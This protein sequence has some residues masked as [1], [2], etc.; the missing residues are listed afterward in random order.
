MRAPFV[1]VDHKWLTGMA[2]ALLLLGICG[3]AWARCDKH[4][5]STSTV[6]A[7]TLTVNGVSNGR[8]VS[9]WQP[10]YTDDRHFVGCTNGGTAY[11][12]ATPS[13]VGTYMDGGSTYSVYPTGVE[14][15]GMIIGVRSRDDGGNFQ[16]I[17]TGRTAQIPFR[18][19]W[20]FPQVRVRFI[21][22]GEI[23]AG[24]H[25]TVPFE[26]AS[27]LYSDST[28]VKATVK[29]SLAG[30]TIT[31]EHRPLCRPAPVPV[32]MGSVPA[33]DFKGQYSGGRERPF[34]I[35]VDCEAGVGDVNFYL[36]P[37][38]TSPAVDVARGIVAVSGGAVG[39]G[40]QV[41][42][43]ES[44]ISPVALEK[45]YPFGTSTGAGRIGRKFRARYVQTVASEKDIQPGKADASIRI[46]MD[47]PP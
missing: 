9:S 31:A 12:Y 26:F 4:G 39:V 42:D 28:T 14:G 40:L 35:F 44:G 34:Q 32:R 13:E 19:Q 43:G 3:P 20:M 17:W 5:D 7:A 15:L 45:V 36:E 21:R 41:L 16:P 47:Y 6:S 8:P 24:T 23:A 22:T 37:T 1:R 25:E 10:E 46:V 38:D 30:A 29:Y 27:T 11:F 2:G 33:T 18:Q